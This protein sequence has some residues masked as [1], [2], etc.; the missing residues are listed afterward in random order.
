MDTPPFIDSTI[1]LLV[2]YSNMRS[3]PITYIST[4]YGF[5]L[6]YCQ[7]WIYVRFISI[8]NYQSMYNKRESLFLV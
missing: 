3:P 7:I 1:L 5:K 6:S 8:K 4:S 2:R